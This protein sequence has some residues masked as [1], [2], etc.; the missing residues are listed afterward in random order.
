M[1]KKAVENDSQAHPKRR[2]FR[3]HT[4]IF[5]KILL[6]KLIKSFLSISRCYSSIARYNSYR[7]SIT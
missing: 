7:G 1:G 6:D 2:A 5:Y 4:V 3:H